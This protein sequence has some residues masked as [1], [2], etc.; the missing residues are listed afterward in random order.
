MQSR[1]RLWPYGLGGLGYGVKSLLKA[2]IYKRWK[3]IPDI[4]ISRAPIEL[5]NWNNNLWIE[6]VFLTSGN[7]EKD[8]IKTSKANVAIYNYDDFTKKEANFYVE[9][10]DTCCL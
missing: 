1:A 8:I 4:C 10:G 3:D 2:I 9:E 6:T 7:C 5:N